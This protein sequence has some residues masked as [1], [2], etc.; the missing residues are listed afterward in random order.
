MEK[1]K[2]GRED[3][4][5]ACGDCDSASQ[6]Y[7]RADGTVACYDCGGRFDGKGS[8]TQRGDRRGENLTE[9]DKQ[10]FA[11]GSPERYDGP[12]TQ[13]GDD[14]PEAG[15]AAEYEDLTPADVGLDGDRAGGD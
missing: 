5:W 6:L 4:V 9:A 15:R 7:E 13:T 3:L 8:L 12:P 10:R 2:H 11:A 14:V 1:L